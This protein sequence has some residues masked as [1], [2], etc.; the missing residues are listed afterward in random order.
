MEIKNN[1]RNSEDDFVYV[2]VDFTLLLP[3]DVDLFIPDSVNHKLVEK[4]KDWHSYGRKII[5]W[6]SNTQGREHCR[7]AAKLCGIYDLVHD[8][9]PK[10][11]LI[12]DD[13][14]LEYYRTMDPITLE[15]KESKCRI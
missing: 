12:V 3:Q 11:Y 7:R 8:F 9:L 1:S 10:P 14:H 2:D 13:D 6:T 15:I 5:I 4:I